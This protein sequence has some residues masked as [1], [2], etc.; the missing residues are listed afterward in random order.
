MPITFGTVAYD[1][2]QIAGSVMIDVFTP[3][4][5]QAEH[6]NGGNGLTIPNPD[7]FDQNGVPH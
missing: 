5:S 2:S 6:I 4:A 7:R 3:D 1:N